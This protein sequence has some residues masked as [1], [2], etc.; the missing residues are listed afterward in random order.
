MTISLVIEETFDDLPSAKI[1]MDYLA[2]DPCNYKKAE[3]RRLVV[4]CKNIACQFRIGVYLWL[5]DLKHH[6]RSLDSV[7]Y[8]QQPPGRNC[9]PN[10]ESCLTFARFSRGEKR[11]HPKRI[12]Q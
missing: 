2:E 1:L 4:T 7:H 6:I 12:F 3:K 5:K 11:K 9:E 8:L 10:Q